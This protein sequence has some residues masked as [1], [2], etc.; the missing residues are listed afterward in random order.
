MDIN[1]KGI[2]AILARWPLIGTR[3]AMDNAY[4]SDNPLVHRDRKEGML[5]EYIVLTGLGLRA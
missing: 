5:M 1:A 2:G 4:R 3:I